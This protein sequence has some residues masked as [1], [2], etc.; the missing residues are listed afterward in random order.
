MQFPWIEYQPR[1]GRPPQDG[2]AFRIPG[3][4]AQGIGPQESIQ[5][6]IP[7]DGQ[8]PL[9]IGQMRRWKGYLF[10]Q[11]KM[12]LPLDSGVKALIPIRSSLPLRCQYYLRV[13][14]SWDTT[15]AARPG[16]C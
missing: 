11:V 7:P 4:D 6:Q 9:F 12:R 1:V 3:K 5:A 13:M 10:G 8:Q 15:A 2:F 16:P 14:Y